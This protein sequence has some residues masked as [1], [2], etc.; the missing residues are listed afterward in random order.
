[1]VVKNIGEQSTQLI[2]FLYLAHQ[3]DAVTPIIYGI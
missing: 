3:D 1:M 2:Y